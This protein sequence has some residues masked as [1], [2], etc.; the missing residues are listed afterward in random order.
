MTVRAPHSI[1]A[2]SVWRP[3][4][5]P[6]FDV[7]AAL[8]FAFGMAR[9]CTPP[10]PVAE[11]S[12]GTPWDATVPTAWPV[13]IVRSHRQR[14]VS[15]RP[16]DDLPTAR[17]V[18]PATR[19]VPD[20]DKSH[21]AI[22]RRGGAATAQLTIRRSA[23]LVN[24]NTPSGHS[25]CKIHTCPGPSRDSAGESGT[26]QS[27]WLLSA[28]HCQPQMTETCRDAISRG[29]TNRA[30]I[31]KIYRTPPGSPPVF[32]NTTTPMPSTTPTLPGAG[33][34]GW[35]AAYSRTLGIVGS[36]ATN[37]ALSRLRRASFSM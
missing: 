7:G 14:P 35:L 4:R 26:R 12:F 3:S 28:T 15:L 5:H 8:Q 23:C 2:A 18:F 10:I 16:Q 13:S 21:T 22:T 24:P 31:W 20:A 37:V 36:A 6:F 11:C 1:Q 33:H 30:R 34:A 25:C 9:R 29:K 27:C 17:I 32:E 19:R